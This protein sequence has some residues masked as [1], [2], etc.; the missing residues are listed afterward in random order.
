MAC[1]FDQVELQTGEFATE[2]GKECNQRGVWRRGAC[3]KFML[4]G[5]MK[6]LLIA[7]RLHFIIIDMSF[8][9]GPWIP[10]LLTNKI[11]IIIWIRQLDFLQR[12]WKK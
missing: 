5:E 3:C 2:T 9:L 11:F 6:Q 12:W 4:Y 10:T 7:T 1:I 8:N